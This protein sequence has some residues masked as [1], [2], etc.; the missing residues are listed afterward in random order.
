MP[1][2][3]AVLVAEQVTTCLCVLHL[4]SLWLLKALRLA[5]LRYIGVLRLRGC[6]TFAC[7]AAGA[8]HDRKGALSTRSRETQTQLCCAVNMTH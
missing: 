1:A 5:V 7:R 3:I 4:L 6:A 2:P 8:S